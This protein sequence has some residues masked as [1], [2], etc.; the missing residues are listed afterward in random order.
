MIVKENC[1]LFKLIKFEAKNSQLIRNLSSSKKPK[2]IIIHHQQTRPESSKSLNWLI[3]PQREKDESSST[4]INF[5]QDKSILKSKNKGS[6]YHEKIVLGYSRN[7]M[8]DLVYDVAKY[9]EFI[10]FCINSRLIDD[11]PVSP[12]RINLKQLRNQPVKLSPQ[13]NEVQMASSVKAQLEI[14]Y[15]PIR[16]SYVSHVSMIKP[17]LVKAI[18]RDTNLFEYLINEWKFHPYDVSSTITNNRVNISNNEE[19]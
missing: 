9:K 17:Q 8:C 1:I 2:L 11:K 15:P 10:P 13:C 7:Q 4:V 16:E 6:Y 18:S 19:L 3:Q 14:G 12:A 5:E